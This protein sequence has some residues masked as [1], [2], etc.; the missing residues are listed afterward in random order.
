MVGDY[1]LK[2]SEARTPALQLVEEIRDNFAQRDD[3]R[4]HDPSLGAS[5]R[6]EKG[7]VEVFSAMRVA[8]IHHLAEVF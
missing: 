4:Q 5:A 7:V 8:Q 3:T 1:S 6:V 2:G